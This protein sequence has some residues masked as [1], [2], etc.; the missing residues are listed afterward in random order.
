MPTDEFWMRKAI[1]L[2]Q[3]AKPSPNPPVGAIIVKNNRPIA[4]AFHRRAGE[5]HAEAL[6]IARAGSKAKGATLYVTLEPCSHHNKKTPPCTDAIIH[7]GI[8]K[9]VF[10]CKDPNPEVNGTKALQKKGIKVTQGVLSKECESLIEYFRKYIVTGKP[11][12]IVKVAE[13]L[14]G[15][16]ATKTGESQWI[17]G[18]NARKLFFDLRKK[19]DAIMVGVN[20]VLKDNPRLT[21]RKGRKWDPLRVILDHRL[22]TPSNYRVLDDSNVVIF[23]TSAS[24]SKTR[25]LEKKGAKVIRLKWLSMAKV[26]KTLGKMGI[27]SLM[28]EGGGE[29]IASA[30]EEKVV[31]KVSFVIAPKIIGGRDAK[32]SVEGKGIARLKDAIELEKTK[33]TTIGGNILVEAY[34]KRH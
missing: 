13:S 33:I 15:K 12:V 1:A 27:T 14:D 31:D 26:I 11:F 6:A 9:V 4:N 25:A 19:V 2:A 7:A 8:K 30:L 29:V 18:G 17:A 28:I 32:T 24:R 23:T 21:S 22:R 3:K 10:G 34:V 16:I 5:A 20:T